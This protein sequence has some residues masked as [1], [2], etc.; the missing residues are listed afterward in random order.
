MFPTALHAISPVKRHPTGFLSNNFGCLLDPGTA[1]P[2]HIR[3]WIKRLFRDNALKKAAKYLL[4]G[5]SSYW[6][7]CAVQLEST[8]AVLWEC[9]PLWQLLQPGFASETEH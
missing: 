9:Y 8:P 2:L 7:K 4:S 6:R 5:P 3:P 1:P